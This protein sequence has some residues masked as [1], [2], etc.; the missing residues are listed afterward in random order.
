MHYVGYHTQPKL[1]TLQNSNSLANTAFLQ[2]LNVHPL[3]DPTTLNHHYPMRRIQ[4]SQQPCFKM[5]L[6]YSLASIAII[7]MANLLASL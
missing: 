5:N 3:R 4:C 1:S 7:L 6:P 2:Q